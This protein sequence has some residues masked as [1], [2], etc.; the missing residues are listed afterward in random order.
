FNGRR[1]RLERL[2]DRR[3]A[4]VKLSDTFDD[5]QELL[6]AAN[7]RGLEGIV[8]KLVDSP[9]RQGKRTRDWLKIKT[10]GRQEFVIAGYTRGQ[11]RRSGGFG[12]LV[13]GVRPGGEAPLAATAA[14]R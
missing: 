5:G 9:Y 10:H 7:Q 14:T 4:T 13:L 12:S 6:E 8:A 11:G 1:A 2:L 3:N